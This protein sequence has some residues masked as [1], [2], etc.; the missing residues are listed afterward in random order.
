[1]NR[2]AS[3]TGP[4]APDPLAAQA[5]TEAHESGLRHPIHAVEREAHELPETVAVT[6]DGNVVANRARSGEEQ[7]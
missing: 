5:V 1:M 3:P 2:M 6:R 4:S 7:V